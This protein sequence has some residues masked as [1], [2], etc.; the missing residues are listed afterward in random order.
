MKATS[1][2]YHSRS[3]RPR[4]IAEKPSGARLA[5]DC[6]IRDTGAQQEQAECNNPGRVNKLRHA[7]RVRKNPKMATGEFTYG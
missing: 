3:R 1:P 2:R 7:K 5:D 6:Q 4:R